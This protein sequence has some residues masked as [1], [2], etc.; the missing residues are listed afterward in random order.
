MRAVGFCRSD[1]I[2]QCAGALGFFVVFLF[3]SLHVLKGSDRTGYDGGS[4][5]W[6]FFFFTFPSSKQPQAALQ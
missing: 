5:F 3:F 6:L 2:A 1:L 4:V